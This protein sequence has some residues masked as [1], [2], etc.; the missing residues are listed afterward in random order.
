MIKAITLQDNETELE[1]TRSNLTSADA[2]LIEARRVAQFQY[3]ISG[4]KRKEILQKL[5]AQFG[6]SLSQVDSDWKCRANWIAHAAELTDTDTLVATIKATDEFVLQQ[7]KEVVHELNK[8]LEE[9]KVNDR[10]DMDPDSPT[11]TLLA[12]KER[13]ANAVSK[14]N[15]MYADNLAKLGIY[16]EAPKKLEINEVQHR[17]DWA[18]VTKDMSQEEVTKL[19]DALERSR[20]G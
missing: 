7:L 3:R 6:A 10:L 15:K 11:V 1:D 20:R 18:E 5:A 16:Q 19:F 4:Y 14:A 9:G 8:L 2:N 17:F 12:F 13:Y